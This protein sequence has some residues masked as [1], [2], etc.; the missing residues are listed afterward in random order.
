MSEDEDDEEVFGRF[1]HELDKDSSGTVD[2]SELNDAIEKHKTQSELADTLQSLLLE[3]NANTIDLESFRAMIRKIPRVSGQRVQWARSLELEK[4]LAN[5]LT[6]GDLFDGLVGIKSMSEQAI[7]TACARFSKDVLAIVISKWTTLRQ[8]AAGSGKSEAEEANSKFAMTEG[9]YVGSFGTLDEFYQGP[10]ALIG[11]PNPRL[12]EAMQT[13][14]CTRSNAGRAFVTPNYLVVTCPEWEWQW[15]LDPDRP[16]SPALQARLAA[17]RGKYPGEVGDRMGEVEVALSV[18]VRDDT[19]E[20]LVQNLN[21][22]LLRWVEQALLNT[23][24]ERARGTRISAPAAHAGRAVGM[25]VVLPMLRDR[26]LETTQAGLVGVVRQAACTGVGD[27]TVTQVTERSWEYCEHVDEASLRRGLLERLR[28]STAEQW[29][30]YLRRDW[31]DLSESDL[32]AAGREAVD[33]VARLFAAQGDALRRRGAARKQGRLRAGAVEA[34]MRTA[35]VKEVVERALLIREEVVAL[36]LYTGPMYLLYNAKLRNFPPRTVQ[37]LEGNR[38]AAIGTAKLDSPRV[39]APSLALPMNRYPTPLIVIPSPLRPNASAGARVRRYETTIFVITSGITKLSKVTAIPPNRLL[40]RGLG[41][42]LLPDRFWKPSAAEFQGGV[43]YGLMSTTTDKAIAIHYSGVDKR[44]ATIF[45]IQAGRIDIGGSLRFVSQ[46]P[47]EDE[48]LMQP[49]SCLEVMGRPRVEATP[50]GEVVVF[51]MRVNVNLKSLTVEQLV[52]RRKELHLAMSTNLREELFQQLSEEVAAV[53]GWAAGTASAPAPAQGLIEQ[54]P[55]AGV[56]EGA[57]AAA[58]EAAERVLQAARER[59]AAADSALQKY[60][61]RVELLRGDAGQVAI[62]ADAFTVSFQGLACVGAPRFAAS[63]GRIYYE[64][65][66]LQV[67]LF[68]YSI[69][70]I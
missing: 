27:V 32:R 13:E 41:G 1:F 42:M 31:A 38:R 70:T 44:R 40:Y 66:L 19:S 22:D 12:Y 55:V 56:K 51:P 4:V 18:V 24:E 2:R 33:A 65:E 26:F 50:H 30:E 43:E 39:V 14:H 7:R 11:Y 59:A 17:A 35:A 68:T 45:E 20:A 10:E 6:A 52:A 67:T 46:Y 25:A 5:Y 62:D 34:L 58:L 49:L 3:S 54:A 61:G 64:V 57:A 37:A 47:G 60:L 23:P 53:V 28:S 15:I 8:A 48:F 69:L 21:E 29:T 16:S 36:R 9:A 63:A